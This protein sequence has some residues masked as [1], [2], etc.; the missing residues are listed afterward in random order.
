MLRPIMSR[1]VDASGK[2]APT[3]V[4]YPPTTVS[5]RS[6]AVQLCAQILSW[7]LG[8]PSFHLDS[9]QTASWHGRWFKDG[10]REEEALGLAGLGGGEHKAASFGAQAWFTVSAKRWYIGPSDASFRCKGWSVLPAANTP[11]LSG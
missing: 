7:P 6:S 1:L 4:A 9:T 8:G 3:T 5:S 2:S 10:V 11:A